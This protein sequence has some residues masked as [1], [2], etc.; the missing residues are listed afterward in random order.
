LKTN[1]TLQEQPSETLWVEKSDGMWNFGEW[2]EGVWFALGK[3]QYETEDEAI[4][5]LETFRITAKGG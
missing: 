3:S 4:T 1:P 5:A 2:R